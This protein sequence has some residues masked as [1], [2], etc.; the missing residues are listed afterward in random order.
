MRRGPIGVLVALAPFNYPLNEMCAEMPAWPSRVRQAI[1]PSSFGRYAMLIPA[2][3][4]G[5]V[6]VLKLPATGGLV[7]TL[8]AKAF[9]KHLPPGVLNFVTGSGRE[10]VGPIMKTG[11]VDALG[12]IG[13]TRGAD[14][15]IKA[16]PS[17]HRLK[18][19][20]QLEAKNLGIVLP[21]ADVDV[22]AAQCV[23]GATSYNGQR[24]TAIKLV[25][26]HESI[27]DEL[28]AKMRERIA[29]LKAGLPWEDGVSITPLAEPN[30]PKVRLLWFLRLSVTP[31]SIADFKNPVNTDPRGP[32]RRRAPTRRHPRQR[33]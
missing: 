27:A 32:H 21:D 18:V 4:V 16:H 28:V 10:T 24:C 13:G 3:L 33:R 5:N 7:H 6:A 17:P 15:L 31:T 11:K 19:F 8:T 26:V 2:L 14:A 12:F 1:P 23:L 25:M 20:S 30:K 29:K 9:A 22:A